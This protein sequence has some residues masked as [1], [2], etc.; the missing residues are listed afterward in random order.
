MEDCHLTL[1][2]IVEEV[3]IS[4]GSV[5]SILTEDLCMQRVSAISKLLIK[6]QELHIA[7]DML[8][9]VNSD[10]EF[11]E[12]IITGDDTSVYGYNPESKF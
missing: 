7:Q 10:L 2:E 4:R 9:C 5:Y 1:R 11:I 12:T 6:Q 3:E 8:Y